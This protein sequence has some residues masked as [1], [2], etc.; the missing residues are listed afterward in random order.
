MVMGVR[1]NENSNLTFVTY[2]AAPQNKWTHIAATYDRSTLT[3]YI[4]GKAAVLRAADGE[5]DD[6]EMT[7]GVGCMI[8]H[9]TGAARTRGFRGTIDEV[10]AYE[11][12]LNAHEMLVFDQYADT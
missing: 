10:M 2:G 11:R 5:G 4:N 12:S 9:L 7:F 1:T 3:V 6:T 8:T